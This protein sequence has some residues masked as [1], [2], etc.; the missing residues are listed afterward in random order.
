[1]NPTPINV[2][3]MMH[4]ESKHPSVLMGL[5]RHTLEGYGT[6]HMH[7]RRFKLIVLFQIH[8]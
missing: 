2:T 8:P 6:E 7:A 4:T 1:M 3:P 5:L